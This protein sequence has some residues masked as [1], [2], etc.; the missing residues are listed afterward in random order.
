VDAVI[1][2]R[3]DGVGERGVIGDG[4]HA[5]RHYVL[6]LER[7]RA[8]VVHDVSLAERPHVGIRVRYGT[9]SV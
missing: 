5:G 3:V 9:V 2:H 1:G 7:E 8:A 6:S 4:D